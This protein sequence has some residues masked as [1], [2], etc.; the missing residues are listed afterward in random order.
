MYRLCDEIEGS[1]GSRTKR[2]G[3]NGFLEPRPRQFHC[4]T[5]LYYT[6]TAYHFYTARHYLT[7]RIDSNVVSRR[8]NNGEYAVYKQTL[9]E[10]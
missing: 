3:A 8:D 7:N 2:K 9:R 6:P 10:A 5:Y 1:T 4:I